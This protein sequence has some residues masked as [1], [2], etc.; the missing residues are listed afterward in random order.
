MFSA[1]IS[2]LK[3]LFVGLTGVAVSAYPQAA[4]ITQQ[5]SY[6]NI[7]APESAAASQNTT[8]N[9]WAGYVTTTESYSGVSGSWTV[10][11]ATSNSNTSADVTWIGIGGVTSNDL[12]QVGTQ[13]I[14]S[15]NNQ[16]SASAFYEL[17]PSASQ[18]LSTVTVHPGDSI[19]ASITE[20][21]SGEWNI[22]LRDN[23][24]GQSYTNT[25]SYTSSQS[26]AEWIEEDPSDGM[27]EIP[28]D[29]FGTTTFTDGS[30]IQNGTT[31]NISGS[32]AYA[33]TMINLEDQALATTSSL[34]S[35][36]ASFVV[37][38]DTA[39]SVSSLTQFNRD[40]ESWRRRGSGIGR[41]RRW[42]NVSNY[43]VPTPS[44]SPVITSDITN[45]WWPG[46]GSSGS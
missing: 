15:A 34:E 44:T 2:S 26:S 17:L 18:P 31:V 19:T 27:S 24:D 16:V 33:V 3:S 22:T 30:A 41:E 36:G 25:V 46:F 37:T 39:N 6:Q 9:N 11:K 28:L 10:P 13:N 4:S 23:S 14:V 42:S 21:S 5:S 8:T 29:N 38:R 7:P 40:P 12:I 20:I 43:S 1:F 32:G 35:N 45:G